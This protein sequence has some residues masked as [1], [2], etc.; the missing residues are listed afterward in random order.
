MDISLEAQTKNSIVSRCYHN[1]FHISWFLTIICIFHLS[2]LRFCI[3]NFE[4]ACLLLMWEEKCMI[5]SLHFIYYYGLWWF[6]GFGN[7]IHSTNHICA[8]NAIKLDFA[9]GNNWFLLFAFTAFLKHQ[10]YKFLP[11]FVA[12]RT[13]G[14]ATFTSFD[15]T[16]AS[17]PSECINNQYHSMS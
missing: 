17:F 1:C 11:I 13:F 7:V 8:F 14:L 16:I 4:P 10:Y 9:M 6:Q 2:S 3:V 12:H 15:S 5:D